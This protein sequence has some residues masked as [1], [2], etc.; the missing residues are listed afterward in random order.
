MKYFSSQLDSCTSIWLLKY[1]ILPV[2]KNLMIQS[3]AAICLISIGDECQANIILFSSL[4]GLPLISLLR[5]KLFCRDE[6]QFDELMGFPISRFWDFGPR[7]IFAW[8]HR[9]RFSGWKLNQMQ[10]PHFWVF[11]SSPSSRVFKTGPTDS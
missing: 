8:L 9:L 7:M 10:I 3:L 2:N 11:F 4:W 6:S 1:N 5:L